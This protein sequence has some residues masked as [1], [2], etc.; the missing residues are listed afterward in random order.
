M[1]YGRKGQTPV[2]SGTGQRFRCNMISTVTNTGTLA[3][4]VFKQRFTADVMIEFLRRLVRHAKRNVYLIVDRH[5][6][7]HS[8]KVTRWLDRHAGEIE[9]FY[10]PGYSPE[11]NPDELLNQDVKSNAQGRC[12]PN[13]QTEMYGN[14]R[15]CLRSTQKQ[16]HVVKAY[17]REQ[18]VR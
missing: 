9:R 10:L 11:L 7:H 5:P 2:I 8:R 1:G 16:P 4:M 17:F 15:S 3:F 12:R 6:V 14:V 18:H 13:S